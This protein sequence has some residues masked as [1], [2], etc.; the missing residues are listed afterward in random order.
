MDHNYW[1]INPWEY[2]PTHQPH[3]GYEQPPPPTQP[4]DPH[5]EGTSSRGGRHSFDPYGVGTS[6]GGAREEFEHEHRSDAA[7]FH[8]TPQQYYQ[9]NVAF[10]QRTNNALQNTHRWPSLQ[11]LDVG[12]VALMEPQHNPDLNKHS[13][14]MRTECPDYG[15]N[16]G[17][18]SH[19]LNDNGKI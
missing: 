13:R 1:V 2:P 15:R 7:G 11:H 14:G 6:L 4:F 5:G 9:E 19:G 12:G 8:Y 18:P 3:E 17:V 16:I 10:H